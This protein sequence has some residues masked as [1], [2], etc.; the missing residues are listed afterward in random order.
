MIGKTILHYKILEELGRGG[1]GVVYKAEDTKL[2]R[3]VAIKFLPRHVA[4]NDEEKQR[5]VIEA[6]AAAAMNHPNIA[7]IF[8][9]EEVDDPAAGKETFIVMEY[10]D[11]MD[12]KDKI[13]SG[14]LPIEGVLKIAIQ[15]AEGL[16]T[17]HEKGIIHRDIKS[18]NIMLTAKGKVKVMDF[19][20]A[21]VAGG[22]M[23]TKTG[24]TLGTVAYMS[25]EQAR[26]NE[27]DQRSDIWAFGVIL[28]EMLT[29]SHPFKGE[30]EQAVTY[31]IV[32]ENPIP[33]QEIRSDV[34][35]EL[36]K[37]VSKCL[38]KDTESR[39]Q[40]ADE[41]LVDLRT[42][43]KESETKRL[44]S[45]TKVVD[46]ETGK[47]KHSF[48][49][50]GVIAILALLIITAAI[51]FFGREKK[52]TERIPIAVA[53][54]VNQT[55]EP[56]LNGLSGMLITSME[57][58]RRLSVFSRSRMFDILKQMGREDVTSIDENLGREICKQANVNALVVSSIRKFGKVYSIDLKILDPEKG[59]YIFTEKE[60]GE[61]QESIPAMIDRLGEKTR[62]GLQENVDD[63]LASSQKV[64]DVT[65]TNLEAYQHFFQGEQLINQL[66]FKE[67]IEELKK[68]V[69]LDSS[70]AQAYYR[71]AYAESWLSG[72]E[73]ITRDHLEHALKNI[74][75]M[76]EKERYLVRA[77]YAMGN[78]NFKAGID[79]LREMEK[80]YPNDKEMI[81]NIGDWSYHI[82]DY[83]TAVIYLS[84]TLEIDSN[85]HRALQHLTWTYRDM[86]NYDK[87]LETAKRY[88]AISGSE[89]SYQLLGNAYTRLGQS[90]QGIKSLQQAR[91][92]FPDNYQMT[93]SIAEIY[94]Y[95]SEYD[96]AEIELKKLIEKNQPSEVRSYGYDELSDLY[97]Y[98]GKYRKALQAIDRRIELLK[99]ENDTVNVAIEQLQRGMTFLYGWN[100]FGKTWKEAE[101]TIPVQH[102]FT[103]RSFMGFVT[104]VKV[105]HGDYREADSLAESINSKWWHRAIRSLIFSSKGNEEKAEIFAD[106]VFQTGRGFEKIIVLYE[107]AKCQY[108]KGFFDKAIVSLKKLQSV[109]DNTWGWRAAY[110]PKS[111]YLMGKI[112]EKKGNTNLALKNYEKF[113]EL[114]KDADQDLPDLID[115]KK[116]YKALKEKSS[117]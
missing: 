103:K 107:L 84:K 67:A 94:T 53:D 2:D 74:N 61:G 71:L 112:Y 14:K 97:P 75:R 51:L 40:H 105:Y 19:G 39:Y 15:M 55:N 9:I 49:L 59:D 21:K 7:T 47:Q 28:Y 104:L 72:K 99:Q 113:L 101:T 33:V 80:I 93:G 68:A 1:M 108:E 46:H 22:A 26:G 57:K 42:I 30:Y 90:E 70:F 54:F 3:I 45:K 87:M 56:E 32:N 24:T 77:Q 76:P 117:S 106:S 13:T 83:T 95:Q 23:I 79:I 111:F 73:E 62:K 50:P 35:T 109:N 25:P 38:E 52:T 110:Y 43:V 65:T 17:A 100:D 10:I 88:V 20:L 6:K 58:S 102:K 85:N 5:F 12:L 44:L 11:G 29:G 116:R 86:G 27:V 114:W 82:K 48:L 78:R 64:A 36:A 16:Q 81:Y 96:K 69:A 34:P 4:A 60:D 98:Q 18:S 89:E 91:D 8:A 115:A 31:S 66:K 41:I 37:I 92:L 63:I